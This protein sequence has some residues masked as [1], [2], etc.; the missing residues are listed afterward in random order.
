MTSS[1]ISINS[2]KYGNR[3][4]K[5]DLELKKRKTL[6][7]V[8]KPSKLVKVYAPYNFSIEEIEKV[9]Y[10]KA[11]WIKRNI[12]YFDSLPKLLP[13]KYINGESFYYLG[14]HYRLK[15]YK[16]NLE[17]LKLTRNYLQ[18]FTK[19]TNNPKAI[20]VLISLWYKSRA[21]KK[22]AQRLERCFETFK[23]FNKNKPGLHIRM[24]KTRWGTCNTENK[25][26]LNQELIK[27]PT[28]CIDYVI[29]HE[30]CHLIY[31]NHNKNFYDLL[32]TLV[33]DWNKRKMILEK[34]I[35]KL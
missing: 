19:L 24:M 35:H 17:D 8:I 30:L 10:K 33:P 26:S 20:E 28:V 16:S 14:R 22:F 34:S 2:F 23:K 13:K 4:I 1:D 31:K 12:D 6:G 29:F 5:Y 9:I 11:Q 18:V 7:I 21:K 25:I 15:I 32:S 3:V 27:M